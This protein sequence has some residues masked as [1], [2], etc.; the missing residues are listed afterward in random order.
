LRPESAAEA[1]QVAAWLGARG[2]AHETLGWAG[3]KPTTGIQEAARTAR[4]RLLAEWC[5][6]RGVLHLM[7]AH[8]REDQAETYLIRRRAGSGVDGLAGM[9]A[10][11]ELAGCRLARPLLDVPRTRL[12]AFLNEERQP[13]VDDPSNRNPAFERS[14]LRGQTDASVDAAGRETKRCAE[15]RIAR[16]GALDALLARCVSLHP[17][18]FAVIDP[19]VL[20]A[21][22]DELAQRLLTRV[23]GC[24]GALRYPPRRERV[25]RLRAALASAPGRG[26]TLGG[27]RFVFWRGRILVLR[28]LAAAAPPVRLE[29]GKEVW[30]DRRFVAALSDAATA[31]L[32][33]GYL[34]SRA[35]EHDE[36]TAALPRLLRPILPAAWDETGLVTV[37]HL[38]SGS[39]PGGAGGLR[40]AFCPANPLTGAGFTVV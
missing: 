27:C 12:A 22:P 8:Q 25:A 28:E 36:S 26:R 10:V 14:R 11:R 16:E 24:I 15:A 2:I 33:L 6:A 9:S 17:A 32:T 29:G 31:P 20:R 34:G 39:D 13:F 18:G 1:R 23:T 40:V 5:A 7:T 30:W 21:A 38:A 37:P 3:D 4:Y 19:G 35:Y